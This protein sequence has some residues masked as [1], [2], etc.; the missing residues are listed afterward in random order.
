MTVS[1]ALDLPKPTHRSFYTGLA[2]L[3]TE[4]ECLLALVLQQRIRCF[5]FFLL[6]RVGCNS[7]L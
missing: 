3:H 4:N 1:M 7:D 5:D 2:T 6:I